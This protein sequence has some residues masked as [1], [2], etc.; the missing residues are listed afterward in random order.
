MS[1]H[2]IFGE[3]PINY[4]NMGEHIPEIIKNMKHDEIEIVG[5]LKD[6]ELKNPDNLWVTSHSSIYDLENLTM[7]V[8]IYERFD[9]YYDY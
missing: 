5:I 4:K 1:D 3:N 7:S 6:P 2:P 8:A 9:K